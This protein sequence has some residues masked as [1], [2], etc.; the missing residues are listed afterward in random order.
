M[1][2]KGFGEGPFLRVFSVNE[3]KYIIGK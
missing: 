3:H 2:T 1:E